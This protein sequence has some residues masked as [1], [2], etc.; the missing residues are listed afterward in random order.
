MPSWLAR[1]GGGAASDMT[2]ATTSV[3]LN[4]PILRWSDRAHSIAEI[5]TALAR[6][7]AKADLTAEVEGEPG[8]HIAARTS[9]MNLVVIARTQEL[10]E[11]GAATIHALTGRHPSR[12]IVVQSADPD[13]PSWIDA[14]V[15]AH[16]ILPREDAP[17]TC[18]ET[19]H[20][21]AG[22]EAGRHLSAIVT[23]LII[24][25]LPVSVWWPGEPPFGSRPA[26]ELLAAA[27]RLIV[28]GSTWSGDGL[29]K[30]RDMAT[31]LETSRLAVSDFALVRQS[32]W[33][34]AIA[35]IFDDPDFLPYLRS[36]RRIAVTY[37]THDEAA[38]P[39]STNLI[40]PVYHV[41]WLASRLGLTVVRPLAIDTHKLA[42]TANRSRMAHGTR[43]LVG[44]GLHST[45]SDGRSE[46]GVV[47]KPVLSPAPSGTTLR[48]E[49]LAERRGSELRA[50]VTA[51]QETVHVR[52]WQDGVEV[53]DRHFLAARRGDVDL[54]AEA[55]ESGRRDPVTVGTLHTAAELI[56]PAE[57][58]AA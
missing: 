4:E 45:L 18:A 35:S 33:R 38:T 1:G 20:L 17:E 32:R 55:I 30:L 42:P 24:H 39:G 31:L 23:P 3:T 12:T 16:C 36:L 58:V 40:K 47:I 34:E 51:E 49:L 6:I 26:R 41:A 11:R 43:S 46:V 53:L 9:V 48:V 57:E 44:R 10:A 5:E 25:D 2:I 8:R 50:D 29:A 37:A 22:G 52:V 19:I 54:L 56:G 15:E 7:W 27:D 13:G 21:T 14:R 28:D